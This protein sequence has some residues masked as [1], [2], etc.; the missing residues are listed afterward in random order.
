LAEVGTGSALIAALSD[1][2]GTTFGFGANGAS[3]AIA[4][5]YGEGKD[6]GSGLVDSG[7]G[8][9]TVGVLFLYLLNMDDINDCNFVF[10]L[11]PDLL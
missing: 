9:T 8:V 3:T 1:F 6:A 11:V 5:G 4:A 10:D 2:S 7:Y